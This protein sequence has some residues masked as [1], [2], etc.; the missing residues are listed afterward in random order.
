MG[1]VILI[2][3]DALLYAGISILPVKNDK[4]PALPTWTQLQ[5]NAMQNEEAD[6]VFKTAYGVGAICGKVSENLECI[7]FDAHGKNIDKIFEQ[8]TSI[9]GVREIIER[10]NIYIERSPSGGIHMLYKYDY[11]GKPHGS[12]KLSNWEDGTSMIETKGEGGYVIVS[13]TP[14][15]IAEHG[16]LTDVS[17]ITEEERD[18]LIFTAR[19]FHQGKKTDSDTE[20]TNE[21]AYDHTD[22]ISY[23]NWNCAAYAKNILRDKGWTFLRF[24]QK[25]GI[26][27]WKRP[28]KDGDGVS[29]TWGRKYN[30]LYVFTNSVD[31]F[32]NECYYTPFQILVRLRFRDD[33]TGAI[34][35]IIDKYF[36]EEIE[37]I[38]IGTD[39]FKKIVKVD[40]FGISR[41]ELKA[42]KKDEIKMD[43]G[44]DIFKRIP[45]FNDFTIVPNNR[46]YKPIID[47]CY[48]LYRPFAHEPFKGNWKWTAVLL[49][50]IFADQI[51]LGMRYLQALY[52]HPDRIL[53]ILV[54]VS[55][56]R[57]TG[58]TTF[59]NWLNM[60]FGDNMVNINPEDLVGSFNS[61][62]SNANIIAVEETLIEKS[63]T[64][65]KLKALA[66]G[67]KITVNQKFISQYSVPFFG[68][69]I[70]ASNNEDKFARIDEE[71]IRFFIRKVGLPTTI[72]HNIEADMVAEIPAFLH[73]LTTLPDIDWSR[74][75]SGFTPDEIYNES[76]KNVKRE[77]KSG[78]YKDMFE[79][80]KDRFMHM[81]ATSL[82]PEISNTEDVYTTEIFAA[83]IDIKARWFD[84]NSR[85][86]IQYIKSVLKNEFMK[87]PERPMRYVPFNDS[88]SKTGT[89]YRFDAKE[90]GIDFPAFRVK[91]IDEFNKSKNVKGNDIPF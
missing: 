25:T 82:N 11:D 72:N 21:S 12:M 49:N 61:A 65:E 26:E 51:H 15:Y 81:N 45:K 36:D 52:L 57:Q 31:Y 60:V 40:R 56:E 22:P 76:L 19:K 55:K 24:D 29:A 54:L 27:S 66:T 86:D 37:Y 17:Q 2:Q 59:I 53:P 6:V 47:N 1:N 34:R 28:N 74:D 8:Y 75:R 87:L 48:N 90:F 88:E 89:P 38:R 35:W 7:D 5:T 58:K 13:P 85:I 4:T 46:E 64:V 63:V 9:D 80:F 77:S 14:G 78:L 20:N 73:H 62:Y 41:M 67:K 33:Y 10:N 23:F 68:K 16:S 30:A 44:K 32:K 69:I 50:H 91:L 83:P 70:L 84:K 39:Y 42:W 3:A 18:F 71:E 79:L 43:E